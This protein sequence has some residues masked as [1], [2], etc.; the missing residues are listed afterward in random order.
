M[1]PNTW[2]D[3][4]IEEEEEEGGEEEEEEE[5]KDQGKNL[6]TGAQYL[7]IIAFPLQ[8]WLNERV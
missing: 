6:D 7:I 4:G 5:G 8:Q 2:K 3:K 1:Q